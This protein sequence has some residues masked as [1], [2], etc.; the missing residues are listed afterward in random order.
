M[1]KQRWRHKKRGS[2]VVELFRAR[3]Q[4]A[5]PGGLSD[6]HPMVVYRHEADGTFWVRPADEF[7]DGRFELENDAR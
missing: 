3:L 5:D 7:D 6:M 2:V 1:K 4:T